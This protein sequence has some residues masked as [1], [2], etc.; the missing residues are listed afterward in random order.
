MTPEFSPPFVSAPSTAEQADR[1]GAC[2]LPLQLAF[3]FPNKKKKEDK[4]NTTNAHEGKK[5]EK[6][7]GTEQNA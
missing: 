5:V 4:K 3:Q 2:H 6:M 1:V 7:G